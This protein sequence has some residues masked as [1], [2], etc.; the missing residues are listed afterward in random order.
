MTAC[1]DSEDFPG[2]LSLTAVE[3]NYISGAAR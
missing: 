3:A 2:V 1:A